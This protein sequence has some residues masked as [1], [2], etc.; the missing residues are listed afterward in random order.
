[1]PIILA[2]V[3]LLIAL[4]VY[5][6]RYFIATTQQSVD[7]DTFAEGGAANEWGITHDSATVRLVNIGDRHAKALTTI[8]SRP[9]TM[10]SVGDGRPW[11]PTKVRRF[12]KYNREE[13]QQGSDRENYYWGIEMDRR[14][15]GVVGI[16]PVD[17]GRPKTKGLFF[18]TIFLEPVATGK[19]FGKVA[20]S[21]ALERFWGT[22]S[23]PVYADVRKDNIASAALMERLEFKKIQS[24]KIR[25]R[26][27]S[28]YRKD[29]PPTAV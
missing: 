18:V 17:Y 9:E 25:G 2:A 20:L 24:V 8:T 13:Q 11:T 1:M 10:K 4:I 28:R 7:N 16:H 29:K 26:P 5:V 23:D 15:I 3:V 6:A 21:D 14:L 27:V 19:G 22:R 12:I